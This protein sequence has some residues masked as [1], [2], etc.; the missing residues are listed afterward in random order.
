LRVI[1]ILN[2][3]SGPFKA[4]LEEYPFAGGDK[5]LADVTGK[6]VEAQDAHEFKRM[7]EAKGRQVP[8]RNWAAGDD[9]AERLEQAALAWLAQNFG[10][11]VRYPPNFNSGIHSHLCSLSA[12]EANDALDR[13]HRRRRLGSREAQY[14]PTHSIIGSLFVCLFI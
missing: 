1:T 5:I 7:E 9:D 2:Y 8:R 3:F 14:R 10:D 6:V 4:T 11:S 13:A 12:E